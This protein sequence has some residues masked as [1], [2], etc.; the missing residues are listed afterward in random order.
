MLLLCSLLDC[1]FF[2]IGPTLFYSM[3]LA[4]G[5]HCPRTKS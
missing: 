4:F 3:A 2:N 5:E 1:H